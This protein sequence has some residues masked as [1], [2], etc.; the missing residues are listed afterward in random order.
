MFK[1]CLNIVF[2]M[3][4]ILLHHGIKMSR[5]RH[6]PII[7]IIIIII[8]IKSK[9]FSDAITSATLQGHFTQLS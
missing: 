2:N 1:Y 4:A 6:S 7:I 8:I 3:S 5:W 9:D